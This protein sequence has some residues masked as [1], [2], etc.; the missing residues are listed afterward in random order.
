MLAEGIPYEAVRAGLAAW[1]TRRLSPAVLASV[2]H[3]IRIGP[4]TA[5]RPRASTTDQRVQAALDLADEFAAE[6][7]ANVI[8][9]REIGSA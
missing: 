7:A 1:H 8:P 3:E 5:G 4:A 9:I 6:R 2:V